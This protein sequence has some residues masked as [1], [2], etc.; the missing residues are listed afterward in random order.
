MEKYGCFPAFKLCSLQLA[1]CLTKRYR[2]WVAMTCRLVNVYRY[3]VIIVS[4][5]SVAYFTLKMAAVSS[6]VVC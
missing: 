6:R 1:C 2:I 5:F 3:N 4:V